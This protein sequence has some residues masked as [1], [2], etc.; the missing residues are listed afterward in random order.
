MA[1]LQ[2]ITLTLQ[3]MLYGKKYYYQT[4]EKTRSRTVF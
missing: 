1:I 3:K 2:E 4:N